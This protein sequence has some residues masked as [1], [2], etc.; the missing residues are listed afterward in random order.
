MGA[1]KSKTVKH[2][3]WSGKGITIINIGYIVPTHSPNIQIDLHIYIW[4]TRS[5]YLCKQRINSM[6]HPTLLSWTRTFCLANHYNSRCSWLWFPM[7]SQIA[8]MSWRYY[9]M[10][11]RFIGATWIW[12]APRESSCWKGPMI[13]V[14][15]WS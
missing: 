14:Q 7:V 10:S 9:S 1:H 8:P 15:D 11:T 4:E 6:Q 2:Y 3:H 12:F 13:H 5:I